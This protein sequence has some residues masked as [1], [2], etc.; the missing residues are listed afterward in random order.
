ATLLAQAPARPDRRRAADWALHTGCPA[1]IGAEEP[2]LR[3]SG[4]YLAAHSDPSSGEGWSECDRIVRDC[5]MHHQGFH[6]ALSHLR[7][8]SVL[9][10][11]RICPDS[12]D[13]HWTLAPW[14]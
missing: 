11:W 12:G 8:I 2:Q 3:L 5:G 14:R 9:K 1:R 4:I 7:A 10:G 13:V 6:S